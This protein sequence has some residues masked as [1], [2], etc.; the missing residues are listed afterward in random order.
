MN[1]SITRAAALTL[2]AALIAAAFGGEV[3]GIDLADDPQYFVTDT[4]I[5]GS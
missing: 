3:L 5:E 1:K 4:T 2:G